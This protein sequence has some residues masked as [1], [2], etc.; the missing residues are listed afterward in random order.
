VW[1]TRVPRFRASEQ[2]RALP[3]PRGACFVARMTNTPSF[4]ALLRSELTRRCAQNER[5][6]LRAFAKQLDVDHATLSQLL[7]GRR[8]VTPETVRRLGERL[9]ISP[10]LLEELVADAVAV[11][12]DR[13]NAP[14]VAADAANILLDPIHE[15]IL[16]LVSTEGFR[17]DVPLLARA[18]GT[19]PDAVNRAVERLARIGLLVME[20]AERWTS[21]LAVCGGG[22]GAFE[23]AVWE[24]A[25]ARLAGERAQGTET[26]GTR[27]VRGG[28]VKQFQ[29]LARDPEAVASFYRALF[30]WTVDASNALG[31]RQIRTGPGGID[32][33]IWPAPPQAPT[34][35]QL[36]VEV[37]DVAVAVARAVELGARVIVPP[38]ALPD[39]DAMAVLLDP[40]GMSF[41]VF[42]PRAHA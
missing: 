42:R 1:G 40:H 15:S 32:G 33:G 29:I 22:P 41:A 16:A 17:P 20:S 8:E 38:Q 3:A 37:A 6:S 2:G 14:N 19:D 9:A 5:Y 36:F 7:R 30:G 35:V 12:T 27:A 28:A 26:S 23:R 34:F 18:T 10:A 25:S 11:E 4:G 21:K 13:R 31:Y 24:H 39:G